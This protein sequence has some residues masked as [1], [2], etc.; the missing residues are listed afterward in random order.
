[1]SISM[2]N[3]LEKI[4]YEQI[5]LIDIRSSNKYEISHIPNSINIPSSLLITNPSKYL[6]KDKIYY[7][8]CNSGYISNDVST[9]LNHIGYNTKNIIGGY[10][11]YLLIK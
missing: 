10:N 1:M 7:L 6:D 9:M 5:N 8:Y 3:L 4:K 2:E 11:Y